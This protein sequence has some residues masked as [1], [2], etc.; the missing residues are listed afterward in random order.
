MTPKDKRRAEL[1]AMMADI[2]G[3]CILTETHRRT[4]PELHEQRQQTAW[5]M[6]LESDRGMVLLADVVGDILST[7]FS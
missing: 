3:L 4:C 6:A 2:A 7:E 1:M 5:L